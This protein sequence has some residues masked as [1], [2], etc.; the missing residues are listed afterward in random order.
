M[1][2]V[3]SKASDFPFEPF[4]STLRKCQRYY[5]KSFEYDTAVGTTTFNGAYYDEVGHTN[6]PRIQAHYSVRKRTRTPIALT[7]Y[8]PYNGNTGQM[9]VYDQGANRNYSAGNTRYTYT[10][11]STEG[12][13]NG[14]NLQRRAYGA[15]QYAVDCEL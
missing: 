4:E 5:E 2:Q 12:Q 10:S 15:I 6:Y 7:I 8:N 9:Y 1:L 13:N 14:F 3:G 11:F